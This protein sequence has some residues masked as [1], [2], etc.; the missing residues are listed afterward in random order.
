MLAHATYSMCTSPLQPT[1][2]H[3]V[4][5][6]ATR[7]GRYRVVERCSQNFSRLTAVNGVYLNLLQ[8][9]HHSTSLNCHGKLSKLACCFVDSGKNTSDS[10]L[11]SMQPSPHWLSDV[12]AWHASLYPAQ[13]ALNKSD[14]SG[15]LANRSWIA[16]CR[17]NG[18]SQQICKSFSVARVSKMPIRTSLRVFWYRKAYNI[19]FFN[20]APVPALREYVWLLPSLSR[21]LMHAWEWLSH[22]IVTKIECNGFIVVIVSGDK[23]LWSSA[24]MTL[25]WGASA[26]CISTSFD[27]DTNIS[28]PHTFCMHCNFWISL[29]SRLIVGRASR[30]DKG[31]ALWWSIRPTSS[32]PGCQIR[33]A[34]CPISPYC[35]GCISRHPPVA[36]MP[37]IRE[38]TKNTRDSGNARPRQQ[39]PERAT[40]SQRQWL[41]GALCTVL[42]SISFP[43]FCI[44]A[45]DWKFLKI[46]FLTSSIV[47]ISC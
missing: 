10:D 27:S 42:L 3:R 12:I 36:A 18:A 23:L 19:V 21:M 43:S 5:I 31:K 29:F 20:D 28:E 6:E 7:D 34:Y 1:I 16:T 25:L 22:W 24:F 38:C 2:L 45:L 9:K 37:A 44:C 17:S 41:R 39:D 33:S 4:Q 14:L 11:K 13:C 32:A 8:F 46:M 40:C 47:L 35:P 26:I 30:G 15:K